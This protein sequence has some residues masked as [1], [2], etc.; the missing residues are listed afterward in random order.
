MKENNTTRLVQAEYRLLHCVIAH[1]ECLNDARITDTLF[2]HPSARSIFNTVCDLNKRGV[3]ITKAE[4]LQSCRDIGVTPN[5][6]DTIFNIDDSDPSLDT[7][8]PDLLNEQLKTKL[9]QKLDL[10]KESLNLGT[11]IDVDNVLKQLKKR[12]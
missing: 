12:K 5:V 4:L 2:V 11:D 6:I 1:R 3:A 10:L 7:I 8:L 9:V